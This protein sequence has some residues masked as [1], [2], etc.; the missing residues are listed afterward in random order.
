MK[1]ILFSL[2]VFL[3][4]CKTSKK[5]K[6]GASSTSNQNKEI[7]KEKPN[8]KKDYSRELVVV[9]KHEHN[10]KEA[11]ELLKNS[12]IEWKDVDY[13][14][15]IT[16][17]GIISLPDN[18]REVWIKRLEKQNVFKKVIK[19]GT[20]VVD[21]VIKKEENILISLSKTACF[22]D[23][24]VY[25]VSIEKDGKLIFNGRKYVKEKG[26]HIFSLEANQLKNLKNLLDKNNFKNF[27]KIYDNP[28]IQDLSST[29]ITYG[30]DQIKIRLWKNLPEK[31]IEI[32]EYI[33][34]ILY[35]K[36]LLE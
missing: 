10:N 4:S 17:I 2:L 9:L 25:E 14:S 34:D 32:H 1:Y 33:V 5:V 28:K 12:S 22:G 20:G 26:I 11:L 13:N 19:N 23:C 29:I 16:K 15:K 31:L 6:E 36:M 8:I 3:L 30:N 18:Q 27:K 24:P 7:I 21:K 35:K